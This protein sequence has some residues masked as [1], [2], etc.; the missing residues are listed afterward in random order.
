MFQEGFKIEVINKVSDDDAS[1]ITDDDA[2][3]ITDDD[4]FEPNCNDEETDILD[5][6]LSAFG[7]VSSIVSLGNNEFELDFFHPNTP[8]I[9]EQGNYEFDI[10]NDIPILDDAA[11][12]IPFVNFLKDHEPCLTGIGLYTNLEGGGNLVI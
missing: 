3:D 5:Y 2:S 4:V 11:F 1:D 8:L 9:E 7:R 6:L 10:I 12:F